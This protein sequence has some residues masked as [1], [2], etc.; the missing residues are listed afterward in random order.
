VS[1]TGAFAV[2]RPI[3]VRHGEGPSDIGLSRSIY[4]ALLCLSFRCCAAFTSVVVN[5]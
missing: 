4:N 3:V 2:N 5:P 1:A